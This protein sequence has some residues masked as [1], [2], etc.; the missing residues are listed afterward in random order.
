VQNYIV[1]LKY[2]TKYSAEYV[3]K[4]YSMA[5]RH[6]SVDYRFACITEDSRGLNPEIEVLPLA[7][8]PEIAGWWYKVLLF[9][10]NFLLKG[11]LLFIDLDVVICNDIGKFFEYETD[12]FVISRGFSK[13][14]Y[15]GMNSSCFR[16]DTGTRSHVY[17]EFMKD[18][19][20]IMKRLHGD[21]DWIQEKV[22]NYKFWPDGW[23]K[24]YKWEGVDKKASIAV[25]HG[26]PKPHE[27]ENQ[28]IK[29]NWR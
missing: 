5:K 8:D 24:S 15:L 19:N 14:N 7:I 16:L 13:K 1:C 22:S 20:P 12:S 27:L 26:N 11:R 6:C 10:R 29:D 3:N 9:D 28:W 25:F 17:D 18:K 4:L 21:Q 2:G 23:L